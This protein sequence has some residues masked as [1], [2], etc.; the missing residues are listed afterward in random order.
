VGVSY[1]PPNQDEETDEAFYEQL[2]EV[3]WSPALVLMGNFNFPV[4]Y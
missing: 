4:I 2:A 3:A 1:I